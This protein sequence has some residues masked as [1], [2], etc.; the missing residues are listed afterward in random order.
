M[1]K[2]ALSVLLTG[3]LMATA[4]CASNPIVGHGVIR[5]DQYFGD[6]GLT[7]DGHTL[8]ILRGSKVHKL[9]ILGGSCTITVEEG[10]TL[11]KIEF[12][13]TNN[14][15]SVPEYLS[16]RTNEVGHNQII[17]RPREANVEPVWT[18]PAKVTPYV[19]PAETIEDAP[20]EQLAPSKTSAS[21]P[22]RQ[23]IEDEPEQTP[24]PAVAEPES[25][26]EPEPIPELKQK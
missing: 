2:T 22:I 17:R 26:P 10:V 11:S 18:A 13:G 4:G 21:E 14:T 3:L 23:P 16:I 19:P 9:S 1:S 15:V 6:V 12:W 25:Q 24:P 20:I 8:T 7:G 5:A